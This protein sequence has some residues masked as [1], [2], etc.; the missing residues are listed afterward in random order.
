MDG[1]LSRLNDVLVAD[2][3]NESPKKSPASE[4]LTFLVEDMMK[5][6]EIPVEVRSTSSLIESY[7]QPCWE[8]AKELLATTGYCQS[9]GSKYYVYLRVV[10]RTVNV[11]L[12]ALEWTM[13]SSASGSSELVVKSELAILQGSLCKVTSWLE[14]ITSCSPTFDFIITPLIASHIT[15]LCA[16]QTYDRAQSILSRFLASTRDAETS[17]TDRLF[18]LSEYL[19]SQLLQLRMTLPPFVR[20]NDLKCS[21]AFLLTEPVSEAN[22]L[23]A[24]SVDA[25]EVH[26]HHVSMFGDWNLVRGAALFGRT[27]AELLKP[28]LEIVLAQHNLLSMRLSLKGCPLELRYPSGDA[29]LPALPHALLLTGASTVRLDLTCCRLTVL[30]FHFGRYFPVLEVLFALGTF[31]DAV[32]LR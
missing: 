1:I 17:T 19:W 25:L 29:A 2:G 30:P 31:L 22:K 16:N 13:A 20:P 26:P 11:S 10:L 6:P 14:S 8:K 18:H 27:R 3:A 9:I 5:T 15:L 12:C 28:F 32:I 23:L 7:I 4:M 21:P 24:D